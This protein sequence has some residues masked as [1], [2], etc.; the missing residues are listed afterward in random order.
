M[1]L[2]FYVLKQ[3]VIGCV[4]VSYTYSIVIDRICLLF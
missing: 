4:F 2:L 1:A 3:A